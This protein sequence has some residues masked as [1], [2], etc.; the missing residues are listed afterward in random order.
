MQDV[1]QRVFDVVKLDASM[2]RQAGTEQG[3]EAL[4]EAIENSHAVGASVVCEGVETQEQ[5]AL[6]DSIGCDMCQG[7][8]FF[9][10]MPAAV[11]RGVMTEQAAQR[12]QEAHRRQAQAV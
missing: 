4:C 1:L 6:L 12:E 5:A 11:A 9:R 7:F 8:W 2:L 10:P 3:R